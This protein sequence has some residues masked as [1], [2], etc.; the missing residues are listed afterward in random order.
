MSLNTSRLD[1]TRE[2]I[3]KHVPDE[4]RQT[5]LLD[6]CD[7]YEAELKTLLE[8]AETL[9]NQL[10]ELNADYDTPREDLEA[11]YADLNSLLKRMGEKA[12]E[13]SLKA[14][15][16]CSAEEWS[17]ITKSNAPAFQFRF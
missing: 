7:S 16:I 11:V 17:K 8:N 6:M 4:S 5:Q 10:V 1:A 9:Q 3:Q 13:Y 2:A 14:R 15:A 12:Q